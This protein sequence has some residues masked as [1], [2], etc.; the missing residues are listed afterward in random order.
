MA[1]ILIVEDE[2]PINELIKRNLQAVGHTCISVLDGSAAIHELSQREIDLVLLDIMLPEM[3]G[4]EIFRQIRGTPAI[5]LTAKSSLSDKV[6]GLTL[7]ADDYLVKPFEMLELLAR[8]DAVLRRTKKT[9][10]TFELDGV[11]IDFESRQLFL[12]DHPVEYTP[13]EFDLLEVLVN[14]RNIALSREKLLELAWGYD[15]V[16]DTRTVDVHIQK[17]R[18]K[19]DMDSRIKTVYKMG[20]RLE[21]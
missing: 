18:K 5:F 14:N 1:T 11:K 2:I 16:G 12:H 3:D 6:K 4:Y 9:S 21:V 19:L 8:I 7:G 17:L 20:Y 10:K 15:Y 13:K